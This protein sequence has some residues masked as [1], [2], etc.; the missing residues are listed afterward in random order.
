MSRQLAVGAQHP[1][2]APTPETK[3]AGKL[4]VQ[5]MIRFTPEDTAQQ[6]AVAGRDGRTWANWARKVLAEA[7]EASQQPL[8][9]DEVL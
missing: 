7:A 8:S 2:K 1:S 5:R 9:K 3:G 4:S 6:N